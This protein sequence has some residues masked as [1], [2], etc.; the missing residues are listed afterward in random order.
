M[1]RSVSSYRSSDAD[2]NVFRLS[3]IDDTPV[4]SCL[5][6]EDK[7][8]ELLKSYGV[9]VCRPST[10]ASQ[11]PNRA[12]EEQPACGGRDYAWHGIA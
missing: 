9:L 5:R 4:S 12:G 11:K 7:M 10:R 1:A 8:S 3:K 2:K 6:R